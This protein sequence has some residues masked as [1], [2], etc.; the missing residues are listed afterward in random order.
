MYCGRV[1]NQLSAYLDRELTGIEMLQIRGHLESCDRCRAEHEALSRMKRLLGG[2]RTA[3]PPPDLAA[4]TVHRFEAPGGWTNSA[5]IAATP[6]SEPVFGARRQCS[7]ATWPLS[8]VSGRLLLLQEAARRLGAYVPWQPVSLGLMALV[9]ALALVFTN[10]IRYHQA[11]ATV[12]FTPP[13]VRQ[14]QDPMGVDW[15]PGDFTLQSIEREQPLGT[16]PSLRWVNV[17]LEGGVAWPSR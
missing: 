16:N 9:L 8:T 5:R 12:A 1:S 4:Q 13:R 11:D 17:S 3:Q 7:G 14:G 2:L 10:V 15:P 6:V